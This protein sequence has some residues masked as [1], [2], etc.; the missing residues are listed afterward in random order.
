M[1]VICLLELPS[2]MFVLKC[3]M[4][5][6]C[7]IDVHGGLEVLFHWMAALYLFDL[8]GG[9]LSDASCY[10]RCFWS[11]LAVESAEIVANDD[12]M[13][14]Q[15]HDLLRREVRPPPVLRQAG[16]PCVYVT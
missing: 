2:D 11:S 16:F 5:V 6:P 14:L 7:L 1:V 3:W 15:H 12:A 9:V 4:N 13:V 8:L 10:Q